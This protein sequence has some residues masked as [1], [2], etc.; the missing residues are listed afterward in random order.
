M[1]PNGRRLRPGCWV[2]PGC[3]N[4]NLSFRVTCNRC[5]LPLHKADGDEND[6]VVKTTVPGDWVCHQCQ[7]Y[8]Y[9]FRDS[10]NK[11][12]SPKDKVAV[13]A[14]VAAAAEVP[15][16]APVGQ[17]TPEAQKSKYEIAEEELDEKDLLQLQTEELV[18]ALF[19]PSPDSSFLE[20][21]VDR[22]AK[23]PPAVAPAR[24]TVA[25][26]YGL[27][28]VSARSPA[29]DVLLMLPKGLITPAHVKGRTYLRRRAAYVAEVRGFL[30]AQ[31][32]ELVQVVEERPFAGDP[33]K[34]Y[35]RL[36]LK[37]GGQAV[38]LHFG[39]QLGKAEQKDV[40][41]LCKE[42]SL[43]GS[44]EVLRYTQLV[45]EDL[46]L[47]PHQQLLE[48]AFRAEG[49][50][51]GRA[52]LESCLLVKLWATQRHFHL[53]DDSLNGHLVTV[54]MAH[55]IGNGTINPV[56]PAYNT[57]RAVLNFLAKRNLEAEPVVLRPGKGDAL[58]KEETKTFQGRFPRVVLDATH[59]FNLL[60]RVSAT[61]W[62]EVQAEAAKVAKA[63]EAVQP[64]A[65]VSETEVFKAAFI[66]SL[67][68]WRKWDYYLTIQNAAQS[69]QLPTDA[70]L[71]ARKRRKA[72][73]GPLTQRSRIA[74]EVERLAQHA[75]G[76]RATEFRVC[77]D[78]AAADR[79]VVALRL[80]P[81]GVAFSPITKGP[82][83]AEVAAS[84]EFRQFWKQKVQRR[85]FKDGSIINAALWED[86]HPHHIPRAILR[87]VLGEYLKIPEPD[88]AAPGVDLLQVITL[89]VQ[90]SPDRYDPMHVLSPHVMS[91]F[92]T[93]QNYLHNMD[94][95]HMP[96]TVTD[97]WAADP[98]LRQTAPVPPLKNRLLQPGTE[99]GPDARLYCQ[100]TC[101]HPIAVV[102]QFQSS[103]AWP[104]HLEA[105]AHMKTALYLSIARRLHLEHQLPTLPRQ[106][107]VD[108]PLEGYVFRVRIRHPKEH[109]L[110]VR[111]GRD[112]SARQ[113]EKRLVYLPQHHQLIKQVA[114]CCSSFSEAVRL[115]LHW[116]ASHMLLPH[117]SP[118]CIELVM[119]YVYLQELP[120]A[121]PKTYFVALQRFW[122]V[123]AS[124]DWELH[125]MVVR[126][127][128]DEDFEREAFKAY[129]MEVRATTA[130]AMWI[131]T[132]Y[133][134]GWSP[135]TGEGPSK[136]VLRRA[137]AFA[138][139]SQTMAL[140]LMANNTIDP[141]AWEKLFITS[142]RPYHLLIQLNPR[143]H[144]F[145]P[146]P[147]TISHL[148]FQTLHWLLEYDVV[149]YLM[150]FLQELFGAHC[151]FF[152]NPISSLTIGAVATSEDAKKNVV[153]LANKIAEAG[154]GIISRVTV[155]ASGLVV[156]A[157]Q[158]ADEPLV[159]EEE[160]EEDD[161]AALAAV[162]EP[163]PL[164]GKKRR[165]AA[166][167]EA[168]PGG[169][170]RAA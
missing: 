26:G 90:D 34:H 98:S 65:T 94:P 2:C 124:F 43:R 167:G 102:V 99:P 63:F 141:A 122:G 116:T 14:A 147:G 30:E 161:E 21:L 121:T 152:T 100:A 50:G 157:V 4:L 62:A 71:T 155:Q 88:I 28:C 40:L 114:D 117:F 143:V 87:F 134:H 145:S 111:L 165:R 93:L 96:L 131:A 158:A 95:Y 55:L 72:E 18:Q 142:T 24:V 89:P 41:A 36:T 133:C 126:F 51:G 162:V 106:D 125:P 47:G 74:A 9:A 81:W 166:G 86:G 49:E 115:A 112:Q 127:P 163:A 6:G 150:G 79:L 108:V 54:I 103:A 45:L 139:K 159:D 154:A 37:P 10:C 60:F 170:R 59:G 120:Y 53:H 35:L 68:F 77:W 69:A 64:D 76:A 101:V 123:L 109:G 32:A 17:A 113:L 27:G 78:V 110:L 156:Q 61:G 151:T 3:Q 48:R 31:C 23:A 160:E 91:A 7:N 130:P 135:M 92:Q 46:C 164:A 169:K 73:A 44:A 119:A 42:R 58:D 13:A 149:K 56:M 67:P 84:E 52:L 11:C 15:L 137:A 70:S 129:E 97:V 8:N 16:A 144:P 128:D 118:E 20:P 85:R 19:V 5:S 136:E 82:E 1:L 39:L 12:N 66:H 148:S 57:T 80:A 138:E 132:R 168:R 38:H 107:C 140:N 22:L 33:S 104:D 75:L 83:I 153:L 25:G 105:I 146:H 29:V